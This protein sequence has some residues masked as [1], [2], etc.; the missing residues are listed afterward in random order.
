MSWA[1]PKI[2]GR[3]VGVEAH[4]SCFLFVG[5]LV[6][7]GGGGEG[8]WLCRPTPSNNQCPRPKGWNTDP[9]L[10]RWLPLS[11]AA[12]AVMERERGVSKTGDPQITVFPLV[13]L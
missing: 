11:Q 13:S 1:T 7:G 8:G 10:C 2:P 4:G 3:E 12:P 6:G 5:G 9:R